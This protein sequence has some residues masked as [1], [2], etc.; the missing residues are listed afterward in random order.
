[1]GADTSAPPE[2]LGISLNDCDYYRDIT[3]NA[4]AETP[5][6]FKFSTTVE[7]YNFFYQQNMIN[8]RIDGT[9]TDTDGYFYVSTIVPALCPGAE[10]IKI[11]FSANGAFFEDYATVY[12][13]G[14]EVTG[15]GFIGVSNDINGGYD[16]GVAVNGDSKFTVYVAFSEPIDGITLML[17]PEPTANSS[18]SARTA[19]TVRYI[20]DPIMRALY[21]PGNVLFANPPEVPYPD[22]YEAMR[23]IFCHVHIKDA[24]IV[25]GKLECL[26]IGH[27]VVGYE[28]IFRRLISDGYSGAVML[29]PHYKIGA[30]LTEEQYQRPGGSAFSDGGLLS[31]EEAI[32][33]TK[34]IINKIIIN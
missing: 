6:I 24:I 1:L 13:M 25:D 22:A 32:T 23:D 9:W 10:S 4:G 14:G 26:A 19:A 30:K 29:E 17:E 18:N 11:E 5:V 28:S 15:G 2:F 7:S 21:E 33:E 3:V 27:G 16:T 12:A 34:K 31:G 8:G 20:N